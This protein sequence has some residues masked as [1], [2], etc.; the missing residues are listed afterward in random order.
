MD[1]RVQRIG[2][3]SV[4]RMVFVVGAALALL[5]GLCVAALVVQL[6]QGVSR[7]LSGMRD[8]TVPL[9]TI[10]LGLAQL[11]IPD[12][13]LDLVDRLGLQQLNGTVEAAAASTGLIFFGVVLLAVVVGAL[14]VGL[15]ALLTIWLYNMLAASAG[16]VE[17]EVEPTT[18]A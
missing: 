18:S 11:D 14:A 10:D 6:V 17:V 8:V 9:P 15:G 16:G 13:Q 2:P 4:V 5:P 3:W 7:T 1:Y 12:V